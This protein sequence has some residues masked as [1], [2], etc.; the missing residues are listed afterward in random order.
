MLYETCHRTSG[1]SR[2]LDYEMYVHTAGKL[3]DNR[4]KI[5]WLK[6][7][8]RLLMDTE[9]TELQRYCLIE[10]KLNGRRQR[11]IADELGVSEST[12]SR[13]ISAGKRKLLRSAGCFGA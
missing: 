10:A 8:T 4:G 9:L 3:S 2:Y 11:D 1:N 6:R 13:H 12:V 5:E 7:L